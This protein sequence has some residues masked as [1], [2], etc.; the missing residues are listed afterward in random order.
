MATD[1]ICVTVQNLDHAENIP[2][3]HQSRT[4]MAHRWCSEESMRERS[5]AH[6]MPP[7]GL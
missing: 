2:P 4:L 6:C 1:L 3:L 5:H 7:P